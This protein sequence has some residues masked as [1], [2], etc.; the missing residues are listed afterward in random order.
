MHEVK[1][2]NRLEDYTSEH[3]KFKLFIIVSNV[4]EQLIYKVAYLLSGPAP[5]ATVSLTVRKANLKSE[6]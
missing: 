2:T 4:S 6:S 1:N 5:D 3:Q